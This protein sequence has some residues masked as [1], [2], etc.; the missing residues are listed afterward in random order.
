[1]VQSTAKMMAGLF[2]TAVEA[3]AVAVVKADEGG[4]HTPPKQG[5][6][7]NTIRQIRK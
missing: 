6:I 2:F 5:F 7:R 4:Q 3:E 1:M